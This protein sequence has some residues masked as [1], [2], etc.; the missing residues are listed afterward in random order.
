MDR[1][2]PADIYVRR[3]DHGPEGSDKEGGRG[4]RN[5]GAQRYVGVTGPSKDPSTVGV[6]TVE[7]VDYRRQIECVR[8]KSEY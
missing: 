6:V 1:V 5:K 2:L 8:I 4:R 7:V 3:K